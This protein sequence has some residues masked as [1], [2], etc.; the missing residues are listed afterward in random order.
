MSI[1][2]SFSVNHKSI[3]LTP[4]WLFSV[5]CLIQ[6]LRLLKYPKKKL[7]LWLK[8]FKTYM[9]DIPW[10]HNLD[11]ATCTSITSF[12]SLSL[13]QNILMRSAVR[14][15]FKLLAADNIFSANASYRWSIQGSSVRSIPPSSCPFQLITCH[16]PPL[17]TDVERLLLD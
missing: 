2:W 5:S 6:I 17:T 10:R 7:F 11:Y 13:N 12:Y 1:D 8:I 9:D 16:R 4:V 15:S 3:W 14:L